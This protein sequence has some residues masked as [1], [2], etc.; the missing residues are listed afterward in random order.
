MY[1]I[2]WGQTQH[3]NPLADDRPVLGPAFQIDGSQR[4]RSHRSGAPRERLCIVSTTTED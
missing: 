3:G 4:M 1:H 2:N